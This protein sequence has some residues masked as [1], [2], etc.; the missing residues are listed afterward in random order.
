MR[1]S[2]YLRKLRIGSPVATTVILMSLIICNLL[3]GCATTKPNIDKLAEQGS[4]V[5]I[6][7]V[8]GM[9]CPGC[10]SGLENLVNGIEGVQ[11][12]R[13]NWE[14]QRLEVALSP[15]SNVDDSKILD[16]IKKANF[17]PGERIK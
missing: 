11:T 6:Y 16:A 9:D 7:E 12:S 10:H 17:T 15:N 1:R 5:R 13:A 3:L 2:K 14:K 4:E 8:F